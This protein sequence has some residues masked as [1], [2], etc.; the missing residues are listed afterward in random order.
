[1]KTVATDSAPATCYVESSGLL[2]ALLEQDAKAK[3]TLRNAS[4]RVTSAL[5]LAESHRALVRAREAGRLTTAQAQR[6]TRALTTFAKRCDI[7]AVT[8]DVLTRA[9]RPFPVEPVRTLDAV[10]LAT[11][12]LV[13]EPP[14]LTV[15]LTRD[16][17]IRANAS[18]A[19]YSVA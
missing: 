10:H 12:E 5:T 18:A 19:G 15:V 14:L 17:R 6:V 4:K 2:A 1:M 7:V 13:G 8:D 9:G 3:K 11:I 16:E